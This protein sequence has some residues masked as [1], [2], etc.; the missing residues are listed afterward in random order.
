[1]DTYLK[2]RDDHPFA[3]QERVLMSLPPP[4]AWY[5]APLQFYGAD[6]LPEENLH[7]K[8]RQTKT[9]I[10]IGKRK[11]EQAARQTIQADRESKRQTY[12]RDKQRDR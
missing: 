5:K 9:K 1:M 12:I 3:E 4:V 7:L 11:S 8:T 2:R 6:R 10:K